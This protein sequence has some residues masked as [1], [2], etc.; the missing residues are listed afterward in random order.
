VVRDLVIAEVMDDDTTIT[1]ADCLALQR[2][3]D[4]LGDTEAAKQV[5]ISRETMWRVLA[6]RGTYRGT[7][8]LI[9]LRLRALAKSE[10]R[11]AVR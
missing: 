2:L 7:R 5:G 8:A 6:R 1:D 10:K 9:K 11:A 4:D 3:A